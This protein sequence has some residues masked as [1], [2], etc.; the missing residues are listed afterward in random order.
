MQFFTQFKFMICS[1]IVPAAPLMAN[2]F[3]YVTT[4]ASIFSGGVADNYDSVTG[5]NQHPGS[6]FLQGGG[7]GPCASLASTLAT[8]ILG[9]TSASVA[10]TNGV[11]YSPNTGGSEYG[12]S[13][14]AADL[15]T[16]T[17]GAYASGPNCTPPNAPGCDSSGTAIAEFQDLV[18][19]TNTTGEAQDI[20]ISWT[21]DG[22]E[23]P[24]GTFAGYDLIS[25]FCVGSGTGCIGNG[26]TYPHGPNSTALFE[27]EDSNGSVTNRLPSSGWVS[28][29]V[30]PGSNV[31][32]EIFD[33]IFQ[34]P[35]GISNDSLNAYLDISCLLAT[36]DFSHTG[37]VSIGALPTGV[38]F[39][40]GSGVLLTDAASAPEP[41]SWILAV[42]GAA[43][44]LLARKRLTT[45]IK[46]TSDN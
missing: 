17:L 16:G 28:A 6:C 15:A 46:H 45:S 39:T 44:L 19:F 7:T 38:S 4:N 10:I 26:G 21:F 13:S 37:A 22:T 29:S 25:L 3:A 31:S 41:R 8:N 1:L 18:N 2:S 27:F 42:C 43:L 5:L 32:S 9:L 20:A 30:L 34:V 36:C 23:A 12:A 40:S 33:G 14:A 35:T 11:A 24:T